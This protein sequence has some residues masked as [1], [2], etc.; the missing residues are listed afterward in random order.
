[1]RQ[2]NFSKRGF[3]LIEL[4]VAIVVLGVLSTMLIN[5]GIAAQKRA[6]LTSALTVLEDYESAFSTVCMT[7]P[8]IM[9]DRKDAWVGADGTENGEHYSTI[10]AMGRVISYMNEVLEGSSQ[11]ILSSDGL[12]Y[13]SRG[14]DPWGGKFIITEFPLV[15]SGASGYNPVEVGSVAESAMRLAI[16]A[17]GIDASIENTKTVNDVSVG[18]ALEYRDGNVYSYLQGIEEQYPFSAKGSP[19]GSNY[20]VK[21]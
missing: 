8:G 14:E 16:W 2:K 4:L 3:S 5:S 18:I 17:T 15:N 1:M 7:H 19:E 13:E 21:Y 20:V 9:M 12:R 10:K 6:R 11:F